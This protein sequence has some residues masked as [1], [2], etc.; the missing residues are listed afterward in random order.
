MNYY[1]FIRQIKTREKI[2][3]MF[4]DV[5]TDKIEYLTYSLEK[6]Q[7]IQ[8]L[9]IHGNFDYLNFLFGDISNG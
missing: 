6:N 8:E 9:A 1:N 4:Q 7:D 3:S 5:P 2:S